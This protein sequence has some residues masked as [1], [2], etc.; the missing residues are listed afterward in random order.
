MNKNLNFGY[1]SEFNT[2]SSRSSYLTLDG[3]NS[4]VGDSTNINVS[5][6][7][8]EIEEIRNKKNESFI[9]KKQQEISEPEDNLIFEKEPFYKNDKNDEYFDE[10]DDIEN[11]LNFI[12]KKYS[13]PDV[14]RVPEEQTSIEN[15]P[16]ART[17]PG[18][19]KK[20]KDEPREMIYGSETVAKMLGITSQTVRSYCDDF[21]DYIT[22]RRK[23]KGQRVFT[24]ENIEQLRYIIEIKDKKNLTK[25]ELKTYL[26][27]PQRYEMTDPER[28]FEA[29]KQMITTMIQQ[30]DAR[31]MNLIKEYQIMTQRVLEDKE[32]TTASILHDVMIKMEEQ[33]KEISE[34]T[35]IIKKEKDESN[36]K[37]KEELE[38]AI[39]KIKELKEIN[40]NQAAKIQE[41]EKK[42]KSG[43]L[44]IFK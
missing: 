1:T 41:L 8:N 9:T 5:I 25:E 22:V 15:V 6:T 35:G 33:Q 18:R 3:L 44:G 31:N 43:F 21:P 4:E 27:D 40:E 39:Q 24:R 10:E 26:Q 42:K 38:K 23:E 11:E 19:P 2:P 36:S 32:N 29:M 20:N 16:Y 7:N 30:M 28:D 37:E 12:D 34:L 14:I 17:E 13:S